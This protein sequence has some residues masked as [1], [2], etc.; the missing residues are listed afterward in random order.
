MISIRQQYLILSKMLRDIFN[1]FISSYIIGF[2][3]YSRIWDISPWIFFVCEV[4]VCVSL[5]ILTYNQLDTIFPAI[6]YKDKDYRKMRITM[7]DYFFYFLSVVIFLLLVIFSLFLSVLY[8]INF[9]M[10]SGVFYFSLLQAVMYF[11]VIFYF[12][13]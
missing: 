6:L 9:S 13:M 1:I 12:L 4:F 11:A 8:V 7:K 10:P 3:I 5:S 2:T